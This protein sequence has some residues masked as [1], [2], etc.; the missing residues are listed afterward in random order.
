MNLLYLSQSLRELDVCRGV[1]FT[2]PER[3]FNMCAKADLLPAGW[4]HSVQ[5]VDLNVSPIGKQ[6]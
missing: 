6:M 2:Q 5:I 1:L 3:V 4:E